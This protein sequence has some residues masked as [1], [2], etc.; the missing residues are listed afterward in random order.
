MR[1]GDLERLMPAL[2]APVQRFVREA[3]VRI[4]LLVSGS[5]QVLAQHGFTRSY[6]I[7]N[8]ASLAASTHASSQALARLTGA[9]TWTHLYHAGRHQQLFLAPLH[10]PAGELILVVIFDH[11]SSLGLVTLF[12]QQLEQHIGEIPELHAAR[13]TA[14]QASFE[15]DLNAG[16]KLVAPDKRR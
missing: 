6:E 9:G 5:G 12:Y 16:L 7:M 14:D 3:R 8:V 11:E 2:R 15:R 4:A 13:S 10:T 1:A